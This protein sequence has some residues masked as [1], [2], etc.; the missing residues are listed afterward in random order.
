MSDVSNKMSL[1][2]LA[3]VLTIE[4][5]DIHLLLHRTALESL[6][7]MICWAFDSLAL[8]INHVKFAICN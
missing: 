6:G 4:E 8:V 5:R 2:E 1:G 3:T 7:K